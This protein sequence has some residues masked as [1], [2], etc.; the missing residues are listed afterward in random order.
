MDPRNAHIKRGSQHEVS[1]REK[2]QGEVLGT[3]MKEATG[4]QTKL[5]QLNNPHT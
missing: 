4:R 5:E 2:V 3:K 1:V